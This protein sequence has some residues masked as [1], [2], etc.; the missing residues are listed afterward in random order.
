MMKLE[1]SN[2]LFVQAVTILSLFA[3]FAISGCSDSSD[4][5]GG[6]EHNVYNGEVAYIG[7][8]SGTLS[9][10][11]EAMFINR[12]PYD[13]SSA[14][15]PILIDANSILSLSSEQQKGILDSFHNNQPITL[16]QGGATEINALLEILGLEQNYSLPE[17]LPEDEQ[18]AEL[19]SVDQEA[20]G[21]IFTWT[22][23]PPMD[24]E[25]QSTDAGAPPLEPYIDSNEDQFDRSELFLT[26]FKEDTSR[27]TAETEAY[28]E[29][30]AKALEATAEDDSSE[31]TKISKEYSHTVNYTFQGNNYQIT[32]FI[33]SCHS[34]NAADATDYDWFYVRQEGLLN[35]SGAYQ[36]IN[37]DPNIT[38]WQNNSVGLYAN[39]YSMLNWM[40]GLTSGGSG[41][42]LLQPKPE[43]ANNEETVTSG[44][45]TNIGGKVGYAQ[46][47]G[48]SAELSGGVTI[49]NTSTFKVKDCEVINNSGSQVNDTSWK[50]E[51]KKAKQTT[52][53]GRAMMNEPPILSR[54][55][56]QPVNQWIWKFS[57]TVRD[58]DQNWFYS[59]FDASLVE[60]R[61][62]TMIFLWTFTDPINTRYSWFW[63]TKVP[64]P[65]PPLLVAP[66]N[67]E[68]T[69]AGQTKSIDLSVSRSW[70]ATSDQS[71]CRAEQ[72]S[73]TDHNPHINITV[74]PNDT[75]ASRT[76]NISFA[77]ADGKGSDTMRVFQS[78]Y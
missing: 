35:A 73:G 42:T 31:L 77:T 15:K 50:Y 67:L 11:I 57:P 23:Y 54:T 22:T 51:F 33:Y 52:Y 26:W 28:R 44:I 60:T 5:T 48:V 25:V 46:G 71:W 59:R 43:N 19:F 36:G 49:T 18:Y 55:T 30:A 14:D 58:A 17:G 37:D 63:K 16:L 76:A 70:T 74:D 13:G 7:D 72:T 66:H 68:F 61:V 39:S 45:V 6:Q 38:G 40:E 20:D 64:L 8:L 29:Q 4:N 62:G 10:D 32:Y 34:F 3:A 47:K 12:A 21:D 75:N 2:R 53:I 41:V 1:S 9:D 24:E 65:Y 69:R 27:D 78:Q 56:F